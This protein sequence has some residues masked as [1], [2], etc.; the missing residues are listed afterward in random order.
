MAYDNDA[1]IGALARSWLKAIE[2]LNLVA[3]EL[4]SAPRGLDNPDQ[5]TAG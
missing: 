5:N 1:S 4:G 2:D 3:D